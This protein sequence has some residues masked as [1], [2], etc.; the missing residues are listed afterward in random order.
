MMN[1]KIKNEIKKD[2]I[3][4]QLEYNIVRIPYFVQI[5]TLTI[6]K[7]FGKRLN[8]QQTFPHGF[9]SKTVIMP[10]DFCELGIVKFKMDL[11]KFCYVKTEIINSLKMKAIELGNKE[12]VVPPSL[13]Y[14]LDQ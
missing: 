6:E 14:L 1:Q 11:E 13:E 10:C 7:L 12:L 4:H 8:F 9:I 3:Y 5:S 2:Q